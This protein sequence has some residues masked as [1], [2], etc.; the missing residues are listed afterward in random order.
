MF[1]YAKYVVS[2]VEQIVLLTSCTIYLTL[3]SLTIIRIKII[4][5]REP[6]QSKRKPR[7]RDQ[8]RS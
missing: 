8:K 4:E 3:Y 1:D 5:L 6:S 2:E 7:K